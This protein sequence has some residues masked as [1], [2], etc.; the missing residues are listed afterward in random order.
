[1]NELVE[2]AATVLGQAILP[3]FS[4]GTEAVVSGGYM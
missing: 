2:K 4:S 1:M 3:S